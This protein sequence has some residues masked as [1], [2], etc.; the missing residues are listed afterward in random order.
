VRPSFSEISLRQT[1]WSASARDH[2]LVSY[3]EAMMD[4]MLRQFD[5][6]KGFKEGMQAR[7]DMHAVPM[8][9]L[10]PDVV[11]ET[12]RSLALCSPAN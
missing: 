12:R 11:A 4:I 6:S 5:K 8:S 2:M 3:K 9:C 1:S 7:S 10:D